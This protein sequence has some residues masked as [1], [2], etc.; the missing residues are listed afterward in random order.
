VLRSRNIYGPYEDKIVLEQGSTAINGPHQ[1]ALVDLA[2]GDWWFL[3]FQDAGVYGRILHLQPVHW[4]DGWPLMGQDQDGNGI[5]EPVLRHSKPSTASSPVAIPQTSDE[6]DSPA[7][8]RQWQWQANFSDQWSSL[9]ARPGWLRLFSQPGPDRTNNLAF[10]PNL[11]LQKFPATE[12]TV[13]TRLDG[14]RLA[15]GEKA[16]LVISGADYSYLAVER[17][18]A[19]FRLVKAACRDALNS[20]VEKIDATADGASDSVWLRV[21]VTA[22]GLCHFSH[23]RDGTSFHSL[24]EAFAAC[25]GK[26]IGA[27]VGL[28]CL[29]AGPAE[30]SGCADF[31]WFRFGG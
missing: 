2:N 15:A 25:A 1:G 17:T 26:W 13:T 30:P 14:R 31:D 6:F 4:K 24:G 7:P 10:V 16:G 11:L 23:S 21:Q 5:G 19:G 3:H 28:F 18:V 9:S 8:G 29:A 12:F 27:K 20:G 22:G